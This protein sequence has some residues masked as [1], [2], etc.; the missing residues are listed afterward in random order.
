MKLLT[1]EA[2]PTLDDLVKTASG[3]RV[4]SERRQALQKL[5]DEG[6]TVE[7]E[8]M[9]ESIWAE[10]VEGIVSWYCVTLPDCVEATTHKDPVVRMAALKRMVELKGAR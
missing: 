1:I 9:I 3:T 6:R 5:R 2:E 4:G 10:T 7:E 8:A